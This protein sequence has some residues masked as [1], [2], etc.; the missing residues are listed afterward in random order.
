MSYKEELKLIKAFGGEEIETTNLV[1]NYYICFN[2][3][4]KRYCTEH[5]LSV[6]GA[7]VDYWEASDKAFSTLVDLLNYIK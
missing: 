1:N 2:Y 5:I 6:Y 7:S 4:D 3:K